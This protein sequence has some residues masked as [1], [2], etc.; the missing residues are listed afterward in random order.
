MRKRN[1]PNWVKVELGSA[2]FETHNLFLGIRDLKF[3]CNLSNLNASAL[4]YKSITKK[5]QIGAYLEATRMI[6]A[7]NI[8]AG[9]LYQPH[10]K[11]A[12]LF[13]YYTNMYNHYLYAKMY[14]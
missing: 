14:D 8:E 3:K 1:D 13:E 10:K 11:Q 7:R 12:I 6:R 4:C 9:V 2:Y 5:I